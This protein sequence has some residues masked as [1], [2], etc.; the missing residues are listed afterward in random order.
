MMN[1]TTNAKSTAVEATKVPY[2]EGT[3]IAKEPTTLIYRISYQL[4]KELIYVLEVGSP[5]DQGNFAKDLRCLAR[6]A[7]TC[8]SEE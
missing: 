8:Y 1:P 5:Q 7:K 3:L 2:S 4:L 6:V